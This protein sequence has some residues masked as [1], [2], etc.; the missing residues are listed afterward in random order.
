PYTALSRSP[1]TATM[2]RTRGR[3]RSAS[4][5]RLPTSAAP[6][7]PADSVHATTAAAVLLSIDLSVTP[8]ATPPDGGTPCGPSRPPAR[9]AAAHPSRG[10]PSSEHDLGL[11]PQLLRLRLPRIVVE[12]P[13]V[14][15]QLEVVL[16]QVV[17][18][19]AADLLP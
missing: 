2:T 9:G 1:L 11:D 14:G 8:C 17:V 5:T 19:D 12:T 6:A 10:A 7:A 16:V 4:S 15:L 18:H 13:E 3:S